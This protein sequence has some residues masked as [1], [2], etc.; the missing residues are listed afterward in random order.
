MTDTHHNPSTTDGL[1]FRVAVARPNDPALAARAAQ[2]AT[3][4]HLPQAASADL[5]LEFLG[6]AAA[7]YLALRAS[8]SDAPGPLYVDYVGGTLS[9]RRLHGGGRKQPLARAVGLRK[10]PYPR[11]IDAT[12]GLGRDAY[13]L[14]GLGCEVTL[15]ERSPITAA[16]VADG[17]ARA[18]QSPDTA[19]IVARLHLVVSDAR[20][21]L[22]HLPPDQRPEVIYLD[23]MYPHRDKSALVKKEMRYL[24]ALA[25]DD[26]DAPELLAVAL[27]CA[28][29]RVAVKRPRSA[30]PLAGP[31]PSTQISS[32]N[33]RYDIYLCTA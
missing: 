28:T 10:P 17:L 29:R 7:P 26:S 9:F 5:L 3:H 15:L 24:R 4:L 20:E 33:T 31:P 18:A 22:L 6:D 30:P 27:R 8:G 12:A 25:G 32:P 14:A 1:A 11:L 16:L 2:L 19:A 21:S 23:P 13:V